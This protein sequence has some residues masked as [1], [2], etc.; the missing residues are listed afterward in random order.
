VAFDAVDIVVPD[1]AHASLAI[2][3]MEAGK[4]VLIEKPLARSVQE[5]EEMVRAAERNHVKLMVAY[6]RRYDADCLKIKRMIEAGD[7]GK[8]QAAVDLFKLAYGSQYF[9][10]A[11]DSGESRPMGAPPPPDALPRDQILNQLVHHLNLLRFWL[12]EATDVLFHQQQ[13]QVIQILLEFEGGVLVTQ[14]HLDGMGNGEELWVFGGEGSVRTK[15]W[16][17]HIPYQFPETI[18]FDRQNRVRSELIMPRLN[19]YTMEIVHFADCILQDVEPRSSGSDS[20]KDLEL[21][22][23]IHEKQSNG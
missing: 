17:P 4:H 9:P 3:A 1:D 13:N 16:A 2:Q 15:L 23:R 19:P 18:V 6:M 12:G 22:Q 11:K 10:L 20:L 8:V 14:M 21:I 5:G 7:L